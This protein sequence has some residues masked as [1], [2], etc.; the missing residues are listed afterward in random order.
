ML[1]ASHGFL[2]LRWPAFSHGFVPRLDNY[3]YGFPH[4]INN[5]LPG[6]YPSLTYGYSGNSEKFKEIPIPKAK[7][8]SIKGDKRRKHHHWL[9]TVFYSDADTFGRVYNDLEKVKKFAARQ[10]KSPVVQS[11]QIKQLS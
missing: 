2:R 3:P 4:H 6:F 11:V 7:I 1:L 9:V 8:I 5:C 10:K